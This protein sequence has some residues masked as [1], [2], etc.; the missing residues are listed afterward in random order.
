MNVDPP[1]PTCHDEF[2]SKNTPFTAGLECSHGH[3]IARPVRILVGYETACFWRYTPR[4]GFAFP[5]LVLPSF[6]PEWKSRL[7][8]CVRPKGANLA[9]QARAR[10]G[11]AKW[12][13]STDRVVLRWSMGWMGSV[14]IPQYHRRALHLLIKRVRVCH[15]TQLGADVLEQ[16]SKYRSSVEKGDPRE[17]FPR[18]YVAQRPTV[19]SHSSQCVL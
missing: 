3:L 12:G 5:E 14:E 19:P 15:S 11:L 2:R 10:A 13:K 6:Q 18:G 4:N 9:D 8:R 17:L 1:R 16:E 7:F